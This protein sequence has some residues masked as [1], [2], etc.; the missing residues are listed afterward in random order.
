MCALKKNTQVLQE[1]RELVMTGDGEL[2]RTLEVAAGSVGGV[3][4][5]T[6]WRP[7]GL[8]LT[9]HVSIVSPHSSFKSRAAD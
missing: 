4:G 9:I 5:W 2:R 1:P 6:S 8:R 7:I 3:E